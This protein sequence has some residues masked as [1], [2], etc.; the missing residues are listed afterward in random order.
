MILFIVSILE[1]VGHLG[2][3]SV[4][5][6]QRLPIGVSLILGGV[7]G[8]VELVVT[9]R[10][11]L[12]AV[13]VLVHVGLLVGDHVI[14]FTVRQALG[15]IVL[16]IR[17]TLDVQMETARLLCHLLRVFLAVQLHLLDLLH[18][19][20]V[21][22]LRDGVDGLG[23]LLGVGVYGGDVA[24]LALGGVLLEAGDLHSGLILY[25]LSVLV[26]GAVEVKLAETCGERLLAVARQVVH[27]LLLVLGFLRGCCLLVGG[28]SGL[29]SLHKLRN[30]IFLVVQDF[31]HFLPLQVDPGAALAEDLRSAFDHLLDGLAFSFLLDHLGS[32]LS[33]EAFADAGGLLAHVVSFQLVLAGLTASGVNSDMRAGAV[34]KAFILDHF[35]QSGLGSVQ[36]AGILLSVRLGAF[37]LI[38]VLDLASGHDGWWVDGFWFLLL[39]QS[40][41]DDSFARDLLGPVLLHAAVA[42]VIGVEV[43]TVADFDVVNVVLSS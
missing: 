25:L 42:L 43:H 19:F 2:V 33:L 8:L 4:H 21:L 18:L 39:S 29:G 20:V 5:R 30:L 15:L 36:G 40:L 10:L 7:L 9:I 16:H 41:V 23:P 27:D 12:P 35:H 31:V 34:V 38:V 37:H 28:A 26:V 6:I 13:M 17:G 22:H 32:I 3:E 11:E 14:M 1:P 24:T